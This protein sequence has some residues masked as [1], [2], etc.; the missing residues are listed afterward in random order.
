MHIKVGSLS[1]LIIHIGI[2]INK[3]KKLLTDVSFQIKIKI[4]Y[5]S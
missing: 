2:I 1:K 3:R 4:P 5:N